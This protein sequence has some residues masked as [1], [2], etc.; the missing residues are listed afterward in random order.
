[1]DRAPATL[2]L[3]VG[4]CVLSHP[5]VLGYI[6]SSFQPISLQLVRK[7]EFSGTGERRHGVPI[8]PPHTHF[9][10][11]F[12]PSE[13]ILQDGCQKGLVR[14]LLTILR[15]LLLPL[16]KHLLPNSSHSSLSANKDVIVLASFFPRIQDAL[17][18]NIV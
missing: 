5:A 14:N 2:H 7:G 11:S 1:M 18:S 10:H 12:H 9:C 15:P 13:G 8:Y 4:V 3:W 17:K 16:D 6:V